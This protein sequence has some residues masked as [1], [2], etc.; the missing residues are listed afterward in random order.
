MIGLVDLY[1]DDELY[2]L[3]H[4][5]FLYNL[6]KQREPHQ[7]ISHNK[8]PKKDKHLKY[9]NSRPHR[10]WYIVYD[11]DLDS[12]VGQI[13]VS[14]GNEIGIQIDNKYTREGLGT[15]ALFKLLTIY[16]SRPVYANINPNNHNS[17]KFFTKHGFKYY[18]NT[19]KVR[20]GKVVVIQNTY[21]LK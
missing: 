17:I 8:M 13:Y 15:A 10:I 5:D 7:N 6:L 14:I 12:P 1:H 18:K 4:V 16:N 2:L 11:L 19:K 9:L 21:R 3:C 20:D